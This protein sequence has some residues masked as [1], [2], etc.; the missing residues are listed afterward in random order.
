MRCGFVEACLSI[1]LLL[2]TNFA[3]IARSTA[4]VPGSIG[5]PHMVEPFLD[6]VECNSRL[7]KDIREAG[8]PARTKAEIWIA[9]WSW[10]N[11]FLLDPSK[12]TLV[13]ELR[14]ALA[15]NPNLKIHVLLWDMP[16]F[17]RVF[18]HLGWSPFVESRALSG[19]P[20]QAKKRFIVARESLLWKHIISSAHQKFVLINLGDDSIAYCL[21]YNFVNFHFDWPE[22]NVQQRVDL[23]LKLPT[24][25]DTGLRFKGP[26]IA[27]FRREFLQRW[28]KSDNKKNAPDCIFPI[29]PISVPIALLSARFQEPGTTDGAI[30]NWYKAAIRNAHDYIYLESQYFDDKE[31]GDELVRAYHRGLRYPQ[32]NIVLNICSTTTLE[33]KSQVD[34]SLREVMRIRLSTADE[35]ELSDG[36]I[37]KRVG[38]WKHVTVNKSATKCVLRG[39]ETSRT[40]DLNKV[41]QVHGGIRVYTMVTKNPSPKIGF[42]TVYIHSKLG[43]IDNQLTIGSANQNKRSF[44]LD[45]EA[46]V[47]VTD[48]FDSHMVDVYR[49]RV[50]GALLAPDSVGATIFQKLEDTAVQ[51]ANRQ[52]TVPQPDPIG[53]VIP[54]PDHK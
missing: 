33:P 40:I 23:G 32:P 51:N 31:I 29:V 30:K 5:T 15:T 44:G 46:N 4:D 6:V 14:K 18:L 27:D 38:A 54:Y 3:A 49:S 28:Q 9:M 21:D 35:I 24:V 17:A 2:S 7:Q 48:V 22:H 37:I 41:K 8:D 50:L 43:L 52:S 19:L 26:A 39:E 42:Q 53:M 47:M 13:D 45:Y 1:S 12:T 11:D 25:H 34:G 16:L 36:T 20:E 10:S